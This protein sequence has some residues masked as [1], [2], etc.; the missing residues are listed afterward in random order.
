MWRLCVHE[1]RLSG[2]RHNLHARIDSQS[3]GA[4]LRRFERHISAERQELHRL[5][6]QLGG[7]FGPS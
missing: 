4:D 5:V 2:L 7:R 1:R 6:A 3:A